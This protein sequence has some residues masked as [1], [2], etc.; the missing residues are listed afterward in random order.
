MLKDACMFLLGIAV[1]A[2]VY[3]VAVVMIMIMWNISFHAFLG[4]P[5]MTFLDAV[6][7]LIIIKWM[8]MAWQIF[9]LNK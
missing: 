9:G 6:I 7:V 5:I 3:F 2:S 8:V 1:F 4:A